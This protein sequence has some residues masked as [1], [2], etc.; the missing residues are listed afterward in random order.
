[1]NRLFEILYILLQKRCVTAKELAERFEVSIRTIYRDVDALSMAGVPVYT[2]KGRYGGIYLL[3]H[4][5]FDK[6]L[7]SK[8]EQR[9]ILAA[10]ESMAEV[11]KGSTDAIVDKLSS[12]FQIGQP[13]WLAMDFSDWSNQRQELY[14][15]LKEAIIYHKRVRFQYYNRL[16][17]ITERVVE[18][19][20]LWFK[21]YTW[22]L[23][24]YCV[25]K[26][27]LRIFKLCRMQQVVV[28]EETF[29]EEYGKR[30]ALL[31]EEK[32]MSETEQGKKEEGED[33]VELLKEQSKE[34]EDHII[35]KGKGRQSNLVTLTLQ[36]E[37][38]Q[39]Y[40]VYDNFDLGDITKME[41]GDFL[42]KATYELDDWVY[43]LIL[44]YGSHVK[45]LEPTWLQDQFR[46]YLLEILERYEGE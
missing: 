36:I 7:V 9:D 5:V 17:E 6:S 38:S 33:K 11:D 8:K 31:E 16:G 46:T 14:G 20:Q 39:G 41:N 28:L 21:D 18:P 27:G 40:R 29:E 30:I 15:N 13:R 3:D 37:R 1:M 43:G 32:T 45:I 12:I 42:V 34:H 24:A 10:L 19:L 4:F 26:K 22:Y 25:I 2:K 44:S 35:D 23:K